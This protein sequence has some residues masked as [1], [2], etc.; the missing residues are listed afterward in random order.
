MNDFDKVREFHAK[1]GILEHTRPTELL[2]DLK[3]SWHTLQRM[4]DV[5]A[6]IYEMRRPE[7]VFYGRVQMMLE[8]LVELCEARE[9]GDLPGQ[10]DA[11]VD[12]VYFALGTAALMGLPWDAAFERVHRANMAKERV[13]SAFESKRLNVLDVRKPPGWTPPDVGEDLK[14]SGW[15]PKDRAGHQ[16]VLPPT[17][18]VGR[19]TKCGFETTILD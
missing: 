2:T 17:F 18:D 8:E 4:R 5:E 14:S 6:H 12:L 19:C 13:A 11:L 7:D 1:F 10:A 3:E 15:C 16:M 9:G